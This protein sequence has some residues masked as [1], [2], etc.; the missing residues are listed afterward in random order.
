M[1]RLDLTRYITAFTAYPADLLTACQAVNLTLPGLESIR[2][3]ALAL[4]AQPEVR[5]RAWVDPDGA[6]QFFRQIGFPTRDAIQ[7]FNKST[8]L[9]RLPG[10]AKYCLEFP[11]AFDLTDKVKRQGASIAGDRDELINSIKKFWSE[12]LIAVPNS[13]WQIG[14]LDPT[15]PD[16]SERNLAWQPPIQG[17]YKDRFKW[18]PMFQRM[19]PTA[20]ELVPKLDEYYT[21]K[22]QLELYEAL[23]RRF[24]PGAAQQS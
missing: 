23:R 24:Q 19:W 15:I 20:K 9:R 17:R 14:H 13:Q 5:G 22:E 11:F 7:A 10:R 8:G 18:C 12:N 6:V 21:E 2:G 3:Q 16:A 4:M 1:N